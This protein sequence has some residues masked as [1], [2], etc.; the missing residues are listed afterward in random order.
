MLAWMSRLTLLAPAM[1]LL[2]FA[3]AAND[4]WFERH[5]L[6]P[7]LNP[8][9]PG[10]TLVALRMAALILG[11]ALVGCAIAAGRRATP[12]G[13]ARIVLSLAM[14]LCASEIGLRLLYRG[15]PIPRT[16]L[17]AFLAVPDATTGW[18]FVPRRSIDLTMPGAGR[19]IRYE[20]DAHGDR[21]PSATWMEDPRARTILIAGESVAMGHGL[22]WAD[23]FAARLAETSHLQVVDVAEGGYGSDQAYL[24]TLAALGRL[25][26]PAAVVTTVLPVQLYRNLHDDR[27]HLVLQ[28][29]TL[30]LAPASTSHMQLRQ[31]FVNDLPYLSDRRLAE[32]LTLTRTILHATADAARA[33]GAQPLFV[34]LSNGPPR[35]LAAHPEAFI[36]EALLDDLPHVVVDIDPAHMLPAD[37]GHPDAEGA[38][39]LAALIGQE[40]AFTGHTIDR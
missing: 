17:E 3:A 13:I 19:V 11:L 12:G 31:L 35:P 1:A 36:V 27:P 6:L 16:R 28:G 4:A 38:R 40:L 34:F 29:G 24:R 30:V 22:P 2:T 32:S 39:Q 18:A 25:A 21:A 8:P 14:A 23:T 26:N 20:T 15:L 5:V 33:R 9:P 10:W 37:F 7:A